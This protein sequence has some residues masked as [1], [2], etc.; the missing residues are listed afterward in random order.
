MNTFVRGAGLGKV[1]VAPLDVILSKHDIV[2]PDIL[3]ISSSRLAIITGKNV[4]GAPDLVIEILSPGTRRRDLGQKRA[5]YER[6]GV[7]EYW[8]FDVDAATTQVFRREGERFLPPIQFSAEADDR[9]TTPLLPGFEVSL[10][11][12]FQR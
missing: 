4:Q 10:R 8:A 12:I 9:L 1:F 11:E 5:C 2:E 7:Q 3:F 6:F